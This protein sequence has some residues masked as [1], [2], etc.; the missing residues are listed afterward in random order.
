[1]TTRPEWFWPGELLSAMVRAF[2]R[3]QHRLDE[4]YR[5]ALLAYAA[6]VQRSG[7]GES[8]A[9]ASAVAPMAYG[10]SNAEITL[11]FECGVERERR[12][13]ISVRPLGTAYERR[14]AYRGAAAGTLSVSVAKYPISPEGKS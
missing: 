14:Y 6:A 7:A 9:L 12:F 10:L 1:M 5:R 4:E 2:P 3:E 8:I 11:R 13:Q